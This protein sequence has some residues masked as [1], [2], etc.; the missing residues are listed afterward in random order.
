M[1]FVVSGTAGSPGQWRES[2]P[3]NG[4]LTSGPKINQ[5]FTPRG[6]KPQGCGV[7]D[8]A[9]VGTGEAQ[10]PVAREVARTIVNCILAPI[11]EESEFCRNYCGDRTL[12]AHVLGNARSRTERSALRLISTAAFVEGAMT[13]GKTP[14]KVRPDS[15]AML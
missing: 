4:L 1:R 12:E 3:R 7:L 14:C 8:S 10:A 6:L 11:L 2:L 15:K 9:V 5:C 13:I